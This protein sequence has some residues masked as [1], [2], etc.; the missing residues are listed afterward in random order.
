LLYRL[1]GDRNPLH[2]DPQFAALGGF[3]RPILHG[4]ATYGITVRL[5]CNEFAGGDTGRLASV[6]G[7]F[8]K[9]VTPGDELVVTA[10][11]DED[12][13]VFRTADAAGNVVLDRGRASFRPA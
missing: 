4:L 9:P 13:V 2:A 11:R 1:T 12:S 6:D 7:R 5:L 10:W 8:T 3:D